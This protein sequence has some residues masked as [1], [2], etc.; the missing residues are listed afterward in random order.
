VELNIWVVSDLTCLA[1]IVI[2]ALGT[3][4]VAAPWVAG[5]RQ[6]L[7]LFL[8]STGLKA[9]CNLAVLV[10]SRSGAYR[11][12]LLRPVLLAYARR[13]KITDTDRE[14]ANSTNVKSGEA[15]FVVYDCDP[16]EVDERVESL[17]S[18]IANAS[19][20][21]SRDKWRLPIPV[22]LR[23]RSEGDIKGALSD[24]LQ[25]YALDNELL[26]EQVMRSRRVIFVLYDFNQLDSKGAAAVTRIIRMQVSHAICIGGGGSV[27]LGPGICQL[28]SELQQ[29]LA[30]DAD[31]TGNS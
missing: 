2:G 19:L 12:L 13:E 25:L 20:S 18:L 6:A 14:V 8:P 11:R 5:A 15:S 31:I 4:V 26:V 16:S 28:T 3:V 23:D 1:A 7:F 10:V 21:C 27:P 22:R 9:Y 29:R 24:R 17:C 30:V